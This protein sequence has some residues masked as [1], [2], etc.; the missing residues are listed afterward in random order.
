[1]L[2]HSLTGSVISVRKLGRPMGKLTRLILSHQFWLDCKIDA[3][4]EAKSSDSSLHRLLDSLFRQLHAERIGAGRKQAEA[5]GFGEE[6][7]LWDSGT[8]STETLN[9][10]FNVLFTTMD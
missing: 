3:T 2:T 4:G 10:L 5:I 8:L 6:Q 7:Q 9:G 1:M